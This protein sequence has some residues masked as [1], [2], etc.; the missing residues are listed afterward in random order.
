M[1]QIY[2]IPSMEIH[3]KEE[4]RRKIYSS[5]YL[6]TSID[7]CISKSLHIYIYNISQ[8]YIFIYFLKRDKGVSMQLGIVCIACKAPITSVDTV[9]DFGNPSSSSEEMS[10][11]TMASCCSVQD[12]PLNNKPHSQP[13]YMYCKTA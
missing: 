7:N 2:F 10:T 13:V 3:F 1:D 5:R 12:K 8:I 11:G 4:R 6:L 9:D